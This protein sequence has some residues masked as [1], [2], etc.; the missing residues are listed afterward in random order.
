MRAKR[1][2]IIFNPSTS[3]WSDQI[4][5][6]LCHIWIIQNGLRNGNGN[7]N[8]KESKST[9]FMYSNRDV[10]LAIALHYTV[11]Y[12]IVQLLYIHRD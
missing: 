4:R 5:T 9:Q 11:V 7:Q 8:M 2:V 3:Q 1:V 12:C 6:K 10:L